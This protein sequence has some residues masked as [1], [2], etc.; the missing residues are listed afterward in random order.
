MEGH[1]GKHKGQ[2]GGRGSEGEMWASAFIVVSMK[3]NK[4]GRVSRLMIG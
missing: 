3:R 1:V 2:S 4:Q